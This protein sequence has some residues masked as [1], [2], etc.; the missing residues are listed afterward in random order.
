MIKSDTR[1]FER[2]FNECLGCWRDPIAWSDSQHERDAA[3]VT[4]RTAYWDGLRDLHILAVTQ[5]A[6]LM[7]RSLRKFPT[8]AEWRDTVN[9]QRQRTADGSC[10]RCDGSG[11]VLSD[12]IP[13]RVPKEMREWKGPP[14]Q[15]R[16]WKWQPFASRCACKGGEPVFKEDLCPHC[17]QERGWGDC[18]DPACLEASKVAFRDAF[19]K[20]ANPKGMR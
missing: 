10:E 4:M 17:G 1:R 8:V 18:P 14:M 11:W 3:K 7:M 9:R 15:R 2:I 12:E 19:A 6:K 5:A 13:P 16:P 20:A